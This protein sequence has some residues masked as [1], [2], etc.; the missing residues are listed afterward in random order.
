M[1]A[2]LVDIILVGSCV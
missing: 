2:T 1:S